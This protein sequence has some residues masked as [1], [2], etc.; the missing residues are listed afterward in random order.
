MNIWIIIKRLEKG[1]LITNFFK[2]VIA[3]VSFLSQNMLRQVV[4]VLYKYV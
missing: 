2:S 1:I 4:D 3:L